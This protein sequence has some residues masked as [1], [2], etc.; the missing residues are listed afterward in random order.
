MFAHRLTANV[1]RQARLLPRVSTTTSAV[2]VRNFNIGAPKDDLKQ[3]LDN[4]FYPVFDDVTDPRMVRQSS[5]HVGDGT[6]H[7][8][9]Y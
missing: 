6:E 1:A 4:K 3:P 7:D 2:A 9:K 8:L 5:I